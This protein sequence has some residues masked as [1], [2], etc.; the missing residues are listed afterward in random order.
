MVH[1]SLSPNL[2]KD[3]L[4][5]AL[6]RLFFVWE[7]KG[8][9]YLNKLK[10]MFADYF[11]NDSIYFFNSGRSALFVFLKSL[12]LKIGDEVIMQS[13][14]CNAVVNPILWAGGK[15]MYTD[16]DET[17]NLDIQSLEKNITQ[18]TKAIIV[19]NTFGIPARIDKIL[20]IAKKHSILVIEDCAHALGAT[21]KKQKVGTFG[22]VAFFSFGRDKVISSV[23]GGALMINNDLL[24]KNF[25]NE[26]KNI[27]RPSVFWT[28]QQLLHP[29]ITYVALGMYNFGGKYVL[30]GAQKIHLLSKA[31]SKIE[32]FGKKPQY[33]P[34]FL[35][36]SLAALALNQFKKLDNLNLH[37][38]NLARIYEKNFKD[39]DD[40]LYIE[41]YDEGTIWL[42]YPI[43]HSD[44]DKIKKEAELRGM[45]LGDW[46]R[47]VI[48]PEG[49]N[50]ETMNYQLG[51]NKT[52]EYVASKVLNLPTNIRTSQMEAQEVAS[53]VKAYN[54]KQQFKK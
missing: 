7:W 15:P 39:R 41:H 52:A 8:S 30:F 53:L 43:M 1:I 33:L 28:L 25:E 47:E 50:M 16:I 29:L 26:Y 18:N 45:I 17:F 38:R 5:T 20:E 3:D 11:A 48:A 44:A 4:L 37:R 36:D 21:Y 35:P 49:T 10:K 9:K 19:Q 24:K 6:S 54:W 27:Q 2:E 51:K 23:Y 40:V 13:F 34:C 32:N 46:Y 22:D 14:T 12:H 42:R 31:V